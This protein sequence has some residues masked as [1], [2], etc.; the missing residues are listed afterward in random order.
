MIYPI[1]K[2]GDLVLREEA[3]PVETVN[4]E[5]RGFA[6]NM[7]ETMYA[8]NGVGLA[9][10]QVGRALAVCVVHVPPE[11]D[12]DEADGEPYNPTI[13]MPLVMINPRIVASDSAQVGEEGCLSFP[14]ITL[15]VQR[16]FSVSMEY[17]DLD[18]EAQALECSAFLA[19]AVQHEIDHLNGVLFI[20]RVSALKKLSIRGQ[21]KRL[22]K[23]TAAA[24]DTLS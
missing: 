21:L 9:A 16:S 8:A 22:K 7:L 14:E 3:M 11:L 2:Y 10:Q 20:D 12:Q 13:A 18:G 23:N 17:I 19:R 1:V 5:I 6:S 4:D 15:D 24:M